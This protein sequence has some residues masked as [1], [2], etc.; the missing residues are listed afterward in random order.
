M[1]ATFLDPE[2]TDP[3]FRPHDV[4]DEPYKWVAGGF[5]SQGLVRAS[6][7][8]AWA[9]VPDRAFVVADGIGG[10]PGGG[11]A[12]RL[13]VDTFVGSLSKDGGFADALT[14]LGKANAEVLAERSAAGFPK[15]GTTFLSMTT[16][17]DSHCAVVWCGDSRLYR[18][19]GGR[20][21]LLTRDHSVRNEAAT[22]GASEADLKGV[23]LGALTR[24]VGSELMFEPDI[25]MIAPHIGD[26]YLLCSDGVSG[27]LSA[28]D[29]ADAMTGT[30]VGSTAL[31]LAHMAD[32][33]GGRDNATA[34]VVE[35]V[36]A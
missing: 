3:T 23:P 15:A 31:A 28:R 13:T 1:P 5:S 36:P 20:L 26:R 24:C 12:A 25:L 22:A 16:S 8:D 19:R 33:A 9:V 10:Q 11:F 34:L 27:Q 30:T 14:A 35:V 21:E 29:I 32:V 6:N 18:L 4:S 7:D 2:Q 17:D